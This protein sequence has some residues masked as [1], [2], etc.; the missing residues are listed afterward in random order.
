[1][2]AVEWQ[3]CRGGQHVACRWQH[4]RGLP[5]SQA[6]GPASQV[7]S[8]LLLGGRCPPPGHGWMQWLPCTVL[9]LLHSQSIFSV[10]HSL[11]VLTRFSG[12]CSASRAVSALCRWEYMLNRPGLRQSRT[13]SLVGD[14]VKVASQFRARHP[15]LCTQYSHDEF[16][17]E[18]GS[19]TTVKFRSK[20]ERGQVTT[21]CCRWPRQCVQQRSLVAWAMVTLVKDPS[22]LVTGRLNLNPFWQ[23]VAPCKLRVPHTHT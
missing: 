21:T 9:P 23:C 2:A 15:H 19:P 12:L 13:P 22:L 6:K 14:L 7:R 4:C 18:Q 3:H 16:V 1:M 8:L 17:K 11:W 5:L 20:W 10:E